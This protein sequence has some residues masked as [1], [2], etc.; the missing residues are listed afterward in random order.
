MPKINHLKK[1][2][3]SRSNFLGVKTTKRVLDGV[4]DTT[5]LPAKKPPILE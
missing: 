3:P 2:K 1:R 5:M 4:I